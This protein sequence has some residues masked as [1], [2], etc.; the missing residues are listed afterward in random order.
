MKHSGLTG[1]FAALAAFLGVVLPQLAIAGGTITGTI[2]LEGTAPQRQ[3]LKMSADPACEAANPGG[4]LGE[5]F[6]V[7]DGTIF[8][9]PTE[10]GILHGIT[11]AFVIKELAPALKIP[12]QQKMMKLDDLLNAE[13]VFLTGTAA[14]IIGVN[15]IDDDTIGNG[16]V[17]PVTTKLFAEFKNRV[18]HN[19]PED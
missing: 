11:R 9:P 8:T 1:R 7:K 2:S 4:R 3:P 17:G 14:E 6:M 12:V 10:A 13:E 18:A 5:V 19:A 16:R 15:Q